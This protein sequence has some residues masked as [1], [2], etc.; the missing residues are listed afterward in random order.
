MKRSLVVLATLALSAF[1]LAGTASA[2]TVN[3]RQFHQHVR[4]GVAARHGQLTRGEFRRLRAGQR[5][6][7]RMEWRARR[8][9]HMSMAERRRMQRAL[10]RQS[11]R[12]HRMAHNRRTL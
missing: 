12:I 3:Q 2:A 10:D 7:H 4:I 5:H 1:A 11:V 6:V 9:G 8:D